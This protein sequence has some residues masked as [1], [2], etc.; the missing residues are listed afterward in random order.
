MKYA[1]QK[2]SIFV[3]SALSHVASSHAC[4][5][6]E[7]RLPGIERVPASTPPI[8]FNSRVTLHGRPHRSTIHGHSWEYQECS[9]RVPGERAALP[10]L[11]VKGPIP[12]L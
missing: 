6:H 2:C 12:I 11:Q 9:N 4:E 5:L 8:G 10:A 3:D 1:I 7:D